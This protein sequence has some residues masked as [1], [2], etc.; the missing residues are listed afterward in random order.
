[1]TKTLTY[2]VQLLRDDTPG[3]GRKYSAPLL[4]AN[5]GDFLYLFNP[6]TRLFHKDN[7]E[8]S[9][10]FLFGNREFF[11]P[12]ENLWFAVSEDE[13]CDYAAMER[14]DDL[15]NEAKA[16]YRRYAQNPVLSTAASMP[17]PLSCKEFAVRPPS[18]GTS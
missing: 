15:T 13:A 10:D 16:L 7:S 18:P 8:A 14:A 2:L 5:D 6:L 12:G 3:L 9:N 4:Y 17:P 1:M 11:S